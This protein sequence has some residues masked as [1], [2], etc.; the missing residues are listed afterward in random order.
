MTDHAFI[1]IWWNDKHIEPWRDMENPILPSIAT[2]RAVNHL[3]PIYVLDCSDEQ[4]FWDRFPLKLDFQVF[5]VKKQDF[6]EP[7]SVNRN[8]LKLCSRIFLVDEWSKKINSPKFFVCD[9]DIF[10]LRNPVPTMTVLNTFQGNVHNNG[11]YGFHRKSR[12]AALFIDT[13]KDYTSRAISDLEYRE[14]IVR[15]YYVPYFNDE[16]I[17]CYARERHPELVKEIGTY[18][19][20]L[21]FKNVTWSEVVVNS[22][23]YHF[24]QKNWG[25]DRGIYALAIQE[26]YNRLEKV[27]TMQD[28]EK[29]FGYDRMHSA[30]LFSLEQM[31]K[32]FLHFAKKQRVFL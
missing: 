2:L 20:F 31:N 6:H 1:Y 16:A 25:E 13:L 23:N 18:W 28:M 19:N 8:L 5:H 11:F 10:W 30:K 29:I 26:F 4:Y 7:R 14:E 9:S 17:Y 24:C 27:L 3:S 22:K 15:S 12:E 21:D 32:A